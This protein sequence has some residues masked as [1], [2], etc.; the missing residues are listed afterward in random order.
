MKKKLFLIR[1][2]YKHK[3]LENDINH[4]DDRYYL[5]TDLRRAMDDIY[6]KFEG[7]EVKITQYEELH[8][9]ETI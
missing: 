2:I 7:C 1:F 5:S 6:Q 9:T 4:Y 3:E 8:F